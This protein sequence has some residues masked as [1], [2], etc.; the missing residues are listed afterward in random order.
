MVY[1]SLNWKWHPD[2]SAWSC[3]WQRDGQATQHWTVPKE[4]GRKTQRDHVRTRRSTQGKTVSLVHVM[5]QKLAEI[6]GIH[7]CTCMI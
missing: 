5:N 6:V 3:G 1:I 2:F 7:I 4:R